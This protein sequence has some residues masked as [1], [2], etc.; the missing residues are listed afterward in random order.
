[1]LS[2]RSSNNTLLPPILVATRKF[3]ANRKWIGKYYIKKT[4][5]YSMSRIT[6]LCQNHLEM[7]ILLRCCYVLGFANKKTK[8]QWNLCLTL[9]YTQFTRNWSNP[10]ISSNTYSIYLAYI[11]HVSYQ[12]DCLD[13][14]FL[15]LLKLFDSFQIFFAAIR[16]KYGEKFK[17]KYAVKYE[18]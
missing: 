14:R 11:C 9:C 7:L 15:K 17:S 3:K 4:S 18:L 5:I 6:K 16:I 8:L 13:W 1:M 10:C 12:M 2:R